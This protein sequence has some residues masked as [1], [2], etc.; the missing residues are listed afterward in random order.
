MAGL[1]ASIALLLCSVQPIHAAGGPAPGQ[2]KNLVTFGDSYTDVAVPGD[3]SI[4]WPIF[5]AQDAGLTLYPF[6]RSGATCSNALTNK[7]FPPVF[8]S[9]LPTYFAEVANG[10]LKLNPEE[11]VYTLW[12]GT[13]DVG[14]GALLT[15]SQTPGVTL[16]DTIDCAVN[17][18]SVMYESGA[19]NFVFQNML[20]LERTI[21]YSADS[22]YNR[23]WTEQRNSTEWNVFMHE[24]TNTGNNLSL[25][26]V[27]ALVPSL[28]GAHVGYFDSYGLISDIIDYPQNYLN[29]SAPYNVTGCINSCVFQENE[30]QA[31]PGDC[32][33][34]TGTAIDSFLW[35]DELHPSEQTDRV[36]GREMAASIAD[37]RAAG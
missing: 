6:A 29:G 36:I 5:A 16:V 18:I 21:L 34:T 37:A 32:Y 26:K 20:P 25:L 8:G 12:I 2:I 31:D 10:T 4:S 35:Y 19:R 27:Q 28:P 15:G 33:V 9:Q 23:Y 30:S 22:Y 7:P 11:T 24:I 3:H 1:L 17:W 14:V 13:N